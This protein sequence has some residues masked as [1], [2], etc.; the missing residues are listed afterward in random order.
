MA[1]KRSKQAYRE[2]ERQAWP[3]WVWMGIGVLLGLTLSALVLIKDWAPMLRKKNL[4]QPNAEAT[5]PKESEQAVA[6][7]AAK[8]PAAPKKTFDFYSVLPEMEVVIPDAELSAKAKAEQARQAAAAQTQNANT[9]NPPVSAAPAETGGRYVLLAGSYA[10]PK[11]ADEAKAKLA[12]L[13]VVAK[14][15]SI[16]I[17]GKTWNRVMVGP[18]ANASDT[19]AAKKALADNGVKAIPMKEAQ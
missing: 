18:Y 2:N 9:A 1:A 14:V 3:A 11:A 7:E 16:T 5:A 10:D 12:L 19:E 13:G 15:Q 17:N 6:D 8:K 4:P